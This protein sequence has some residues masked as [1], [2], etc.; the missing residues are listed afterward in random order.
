MMG[1]GSGFQVP[2]SEKLF[3]DRP[4]NS[5]AN[6]IVK[7][8][9]RRYFQLGE[10]AYTNDVLSLSFTDRED[11]EIEAKDTEEEISIIFASDPPPADTDMSISGVYL[12]DD[13]ATYLGFGFN[14]S[15]LNH[16]VVNLLDSSDQLHGNT[17]VNIFKVKSENAKYPVQNLSLDVQFDGVHSSIF[18]PEHFFLVTGGYELTF[19]VPHKHDLNVTVSVKNIMC[20]Y[21]HEASGIWNSDG[22]KVSPESN[23]TSTVC[24]CNHLT[25]FTTRSD[26]G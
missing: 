16:A 4:P 24:L 9:N 5:V 10:K 20:G 23:L 3:A 18:F 13:N 8:L 1:D 25:T 21:L 11:N 12:E 6:R 17:T 26:M 2:A 19:K 15:R 7:R 22:C 14:I